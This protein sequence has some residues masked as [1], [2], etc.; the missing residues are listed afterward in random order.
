MLWWM[1]AGFFIWLSL[2]EI[3]YGFVPPPGY[4]FPYPTISIPYVLVTAALGL[5]AAY[6]PIRYAYFEHFLSQKAQIIAESKKAKVHCNTFINSVMDLNMLAAAYAQEETGRIVF[7][8]PWCKTLLHH[9]EH[10]ENA[11]EAGI[12]SVQMFAHEAMHIRGES[13]EAMAECQAVQRYAR[14]AMALG[15]GE[16]MAREHGLRYYH[17]YYQRRARIGGMAGNY[18]SEQ[19]KPGGAWDE[20]LIDSTW[21]A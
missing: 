8:H 7:Q 11:S 12:Y 3:Y 2:R 17:G 9:L 4:D 10:P 13:D 20:R 1:I 15:I 14:V 18:Y 16:Y 21:G 19:C 6:T 5:A